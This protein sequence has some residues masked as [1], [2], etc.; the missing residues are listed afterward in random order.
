MT[1]LQALDFGYTE[2]NWE[3]LW[4]EARERV[5]PEPE[6]DWREPEP[7]PELEARLSELEFE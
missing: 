6:H 2:P 4:T 5:T 3:Q 7:T 1:D